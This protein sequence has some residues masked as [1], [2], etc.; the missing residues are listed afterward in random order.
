V[1]QNLVVKPMNGK[2]KRYAIITGERRYR[3]LRLLEDRGELPDGFTVPVE[4]RGSLTKDESL[5][6]A[7][8]ENLQRQNLTPLEETAALTKLIRKGVTLEDLAA[9]TGLSPSTIKRRLA[10]N[11]LCDDARKALEEGE[12]SLAQA[13]ALTLANETL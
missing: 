3:A 12:I 5:R 9:Q 1:L 6:I 8:V 2:G 7:A 13:E 11:G 10:L 4:V